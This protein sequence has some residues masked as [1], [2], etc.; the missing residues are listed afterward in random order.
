MTSGKHGV[1]DVLDPFTT[2][3]PLALEGPAL[4]AFAHP[5]RMRLYDELERSGP[6]TSA[7]LAAWTGE[8]RGATSYHLRQLARHG[9][10]EE[11]PGR[12]TAKERWWRARPG[13]Y[14]FN[15]D[16]LRRDPDPGTA[17]A[18]EALIGSL[19]Q[20]WSTELGTWV[21]AARTMPPEWVQ[22]SMNHRSAK[23]LSRAELGEMVAEVLAVIDRYPDHAPGSSA[24][25]APDAEE[26]VRVS[27]AFDALPWAPSVP[28]DER[29]TSAVAG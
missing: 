2:P 21:E 5:L 29:D 13:G 1:D 9:L 23:H 6:A 18:A 8:S 24:D 17:Q 25:D 20:R 16:R 10:L 12:G 7:Q 22:A 15:G 28:A 11:V 4:K 14:R 19:V 26:R 3:K 27:V